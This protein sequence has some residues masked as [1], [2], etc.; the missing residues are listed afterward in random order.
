MIKKYQDEI[1][2]GQIVQKG[3]RDC[4]S[5]YEMIRPILARFK[6]RFTL[7]DFGANVGYFAFRAAHEF[8]NAVCIL[9]EG[10]KYA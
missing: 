9:V 2:D 5:R 3:G 4:A 1:V 8:P 10:G 6:R 7:L